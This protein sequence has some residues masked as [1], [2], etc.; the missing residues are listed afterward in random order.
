M[1]GFVRLGKGV[2]VGNVRS[3]RPDSGRFE[4]VESLTDEAAL[5]E[6]VDN[7]LRA[8]LDG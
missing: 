3:F 5:F 1:V 6:L 8:V 4:N 7:L 2:L